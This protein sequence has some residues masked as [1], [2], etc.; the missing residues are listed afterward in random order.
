MS[1]PTSGG[2]ERPDHEPDI[3]PENGHDGVQDQPTEPAS[4]DPTA[5][6]WA[7]PTAPIP[8]PPS[9]P[10]AAQPP[11]EQPADHPQATP[12][13]PPP[14][15]NPYAQQPPPAPYPQQS[16]QPYGQPQQGPQYP[17]YGQQPYSTGPHPNA[18]A[19]AIVLTVLSGISLFICNILAIA[20]L[21][22]GIVS[23]TKNP[24]DPVGSRRLTKIGWIV[25]AGVWVLGILIVIGYLVLFATAVNNGSGPNTTFGN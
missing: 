21:I 13:V 18:N 14:L 9:A 2:K 17:A 19:A 8:T 7:D 6:I 5:P 20:P 3:D 15:S 10:G 25:F 1:E 22:L 11:G 16:A 12:P 24:T 23:L 4:S